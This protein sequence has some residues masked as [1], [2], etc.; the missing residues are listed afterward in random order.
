MYSIQYELL[1]V[2]FVY[3]VSSQSQLGM[4]ATDIDLFH[5]NTRRNL[6]VNFQRNYGYAI[7]MIQ[8]VLLI[9]I[10]TVKNIYDSYH[11]D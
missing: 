1:M 3:S 4:I 10:T 9:I 2:I 7:Y 11:F 5:L 6:S 8:S